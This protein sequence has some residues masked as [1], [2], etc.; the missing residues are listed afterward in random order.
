MS[1]VVYSPLATCG[2][3][4]LM[5][6]HEGG[7]SHTLPP[8]FTGHAQLNFSFMSVQSSVHVPACKQGFDRQH[9]FKQLLASCVNYTKHVFM[10]YTCITALR[11]YPRVFNQADDVHV[12]Y[13]KSNPRK[14]DWILMGYSRCISSQGVQF[15]AP[16][17]SRDALHAL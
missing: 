16:F 17:E 10:C 8:K 4:D 1:C 14:T 3:L 13:S 15:R 5:S 11:K 6:R 2:S 12:G 9:P 7:I